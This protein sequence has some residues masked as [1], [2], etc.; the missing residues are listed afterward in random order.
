MINVRGY[1]Q[2]ILLLSLFRAL[3]ITSD[4]DVYDT[5]LAGVPDKERIAYDEIIY[6]LILSHDKFLD[7]IGKSDLELLAEFTRSKSRFEIVQNLHESLFS[8]VEGT[9]DDNGA[10]F[11]RKAYLLGQMLKMGLD[12]ETG[13]RA[14]SDRDSFQ[15]KRF[16]TSGV[17]LFEEFRRIYR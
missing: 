13:R 16:V 11:R 17:L 5:V 3:G 2:P 4:R 10:T 14:P 7:K 12:V 9:N 6:Q 1:S 15:F 8:H